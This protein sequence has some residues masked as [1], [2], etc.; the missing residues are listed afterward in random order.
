MLESL[1]KAKGR[2]TAE[3]SDRARQLLAK[4][5]ECAGW[6]TSAPS[7]GAL[8]RRMNRRFD[9]ASWREHWVTREQP[10]F[11]AG[12]DDAAA[13]AHEFRR[14]FGED[15]VSAV[16]KRAEKICRGRIDLLGYRDLSF[17][18]PV[19]W[20][21]EPVSG[22]RS[23]LV[24][25][26]RI[27]ELDADGSGDKKIVWELNRCQHFV[28]LGRAYALTGDERFAASFAEQL[29]G[30]MEQNPPKRGINWVSS[31]EVAF[32]AIA[33]LWA[34]RLFRGSL[35]LTPELLERATSYLHVHGRHL[36]RYLSTYSSPNTHLTGEALGL[37]YLGIVLPEF[38]RARQWRD[39]GS[40]IL[41]AAIL[42]HVRA[43][44]VYFEQSTYYH[45]YTADF[46]THFSILSGRNDLGFDSDTKRRL[47]SMFDYLLFVARPDGTTP[48]IGDDDGGRL[49]PLD[50]RPCDDFRAAL[51]NGAVLFKRGEL[52]FGAGQLAEETL[53]LLGAA[54]AKTF[55]ELIAIEPA[56][57]SRAFAASGVYVMRDG[58]T[59]DATAL[60]IDCGPHGALT[61]AHGHAD[62][63]SFDLTVGGR[64]MLVDPGTYTYTGS[65]SLRDRFRSTA[66]HNALT[67]EGAASADPAGPF[68]WTRKAEGTVAQWSSGPRFD[69]FSGRHDGYTN[70]DPPVTHR[71]SILFI[72][73][74]YLIIRDRLERS[75]A[76]D[77][78]LNFQGAIGTTCASAERG[79]NWSAE[80][81][82]D[83]LSLD[84]ATFGGKGE[85]RINSGAVSRCYGSQEAAPTAV[86]SASV[87]RDDELITFLCPRQGPRRV[88][89]AE[90]EL[91]NGR[92]ISA[93]TSTEPDRRDLLLLGN[94]RVL[95]HDDVI[96]DFAWTWVRF[97][98]GV[99]VEAILLSGRAFRIGNESL[100]EANE[101]VEFARISRVTGKWVIETG[102]ELMTKPVRPTDFAVA[103]PGRQALDAKTY[104][105]D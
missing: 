8:W 33:W 27:D 39:T 82:S 77:C 72:H 74:E 101:R 85:W 89:V 102:A 76:S 21:L 105:R 69:F 63:L 41:N 31:L 6:Q 19:D 16:V 12:V 25:W 5:A 34:L 103:S 45:R 58:W 4:W 38:E 98:G 40:A 32:R 50:Q 90:F 52:K 26:S 56:H 81:A 87:E 36:E 11:F 24:H 88:I 10:R 78:E 95:Q 47:A 84:L 53:W 67:I 104:V 55:D 92:G 66:A 60:V 35:H 75:A 13:T 79:V 18:S 65:A 28:D 9:A 86:Y 83:H 14:R 42:E 43:D 61:G 7:G 46:Y 97:A 59:P 57:S 100:L 91:L 51:S 68:S 99:L 80:G 30:W 54:G 23:A 17:G 64:A 22:K 62:A 3:L 37:F 96:S 71:R 49:M 1:E 70:L 94:G 20:H 48:L 73:G 44:G 93:A 29:N 2:N 15:A